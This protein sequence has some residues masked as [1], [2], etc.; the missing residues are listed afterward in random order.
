MRMRFEDLRQTAFTFSILALALFGFGLV[1]YCTV[2]GA[3]LIS[4]S[5]QYVSTAKNI[6]AGREFGYVIANG[7]TVPLTQYP[8]FFSLLLAGFEV[9][10]VDALE[11]AR[12][13]NAFLFGLNILLVGISV[14]KISGSTGFALLGPL[15]TIFSSSLVEAHSWALSEPLYLGLSLAGFL[16]LSEYLKES[17]RGWIL[18]AGILFGL[19]FL[20][21]YVG[22]SLV[23]CGLCIVLLNNKLDRGEKLVDGLLLAV[24]SLLPMGLWTLRNYMLTGTLNNR[25][26]SFAPITPKNMLSAVDTF[27]GWII[28]DAL[29]AGREKLILTVGGVLLV[30]VLLAWLIFLRKLPYAAKL[31]LVLAGSD[32]LFKSHFLYGGIYFGMVVLSKAY[33]DDNIGFTERMFSPMLV[34]GLILISAYLANLWQ[35]DKPVI[36]LGVTLCAVYLLSYYMVGTIHL[37]PRLHDKGIGIARKSWHNAESIQLLPALSSRPIFS[38]SP[39]SL[40]LWTENTGYNL[41]DF[42]VFRN[43]KNQGE[44]VLVI[45]HHLPTNPR[46]ERLSS[47]LKVLVSDQVAT[48]YLYEP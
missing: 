13:L 48:V 8:P 15:L 11:G 3:G 31:V 27:L 39:S 32:D 4:D 47:G 10:G 14:K 44:A 45:F 38:N 2:W 9:F 42:E 37:A 43:Q 40:Y 16:S 20:T 34:S 23:V 41:N 5:F 26:L 21:R 6:A 25:I 17:R 19:G 24:I 7:Q 28:P 33:F 1:L 30:V 18:A 35:A 12:F 46:L 22:L 36:R 29:V